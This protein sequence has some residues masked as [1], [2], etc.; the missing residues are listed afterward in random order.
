MG[1]SNSLQPDLWGNVKAGASCSI[2]GRPLSDPVS[3]LAGIG[4][5]CA[6]SRASQ[7]SVIEAAQGAE[8][9][10]FADVADL[11][12]ADPPIERRIAFGLTD[13]GRVWSNV[14]HSVVQYSAGGYAFGYGGSGPADLALNIAQA[15]CILDRYE[16]SR[17]DGDRG[18]GWAFDLAFACHQDLKW[19]FVAGA[20]SDTGAEYE[21]A[22]L[23][24]WLRAWR[25]DNAEAVDFWRLQASIGD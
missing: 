22:E 4:P 2:C 1:V 3:V 16:G 7:L 25:A 14:P 15:L 5:V 11:V 10:G 12:T 17:I 18:A 21:T 13:T 8:R 23:L 19:A 9:C 24:D 6:G 20:P